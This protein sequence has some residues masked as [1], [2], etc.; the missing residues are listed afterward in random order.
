M[1]LIWKELQKV[2][3]S[4]KSKLHSNVFSVPF[5]LKKRKNLQ[6]VLDLYSTYTYSYKIHG[7]RIEMYIY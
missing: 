5:M 3:L 6:E 4:V 2:F 1:G 7:V